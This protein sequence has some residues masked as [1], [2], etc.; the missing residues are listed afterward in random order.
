[1]FGRL[2]AGFRKDRFIIQAREDQKWA[3]YPGCPEGMMECR[4][5]CECLNTKT[6][7]YAWIKARSEALRIM[8]GCKHQQT[9]PWRTSIFPEFVSGK[10][11]TRCQAVQRLPGEKWEPEN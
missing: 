10:Q 4:R 8:E 5:L 2:L 1:M 11:C 6:P 7:S 3:D 9:R